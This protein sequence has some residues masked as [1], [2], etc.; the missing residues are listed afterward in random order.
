MSGKS[1]AILNMTSPPINAIE[2]FPRVRLGHAPTPLDAAPRLGTAIGIEL[3][4]KRD[5]CTGLAMGGNK[6]R[7]LEF[8]LGEAQSRDAD[9]LLITSA[10]QSNYVRVAA[11]AGRQLGMETHIQLEE[12]VPDMDALYRSSGNVLLDRL[13]GAT[14]HSFPVGDDEPAADASLDLLAQSL[15][16]EG[17]RPYV[18]HLA[19]AHPPLGALGYV[20]AAGETLAQARDLGLEFDAVVC[21]TGSAL[22]HAGLLVGFR[23]LGKAVP[24]Y[25][26]CVRRDAGGQVARVSKVAED[27]AGMIERPEVFDAGDVMAFDGVLAP[28]YGRLNDTVREAIALAAR[29]EGLLLDPVYTGKTMAGLIEHVRSGVIPA[30]SRVLF[31]HTGGLP[32]LFAYGDRLGPWLSDV[33]WAEG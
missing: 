22:T 25:G 17:R 6:V 9:T 26:I 5:D 10:V 18:I 31:V 14:L 7:Q 21:P 33:P 16:E 12:R 11:A 28:G 27:L 15:A 3:W 19:P 1:K 23:A 32:A 29:Q 4:I 30:G 2:K 24:V 20:I 13:F 8:P